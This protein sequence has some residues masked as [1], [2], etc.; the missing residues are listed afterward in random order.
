MNKDQQWLSYVAQLRKEHDKELN[1]LSE[2]VEFYKQKAED[3]SRSCDRTEEGLEEAVELLESVYNN[4]DQYHL[5]FY[6]KGGECYEKL[7]D[8]LGK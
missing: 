6:Y 3:L 7:K 2:K 4:V 8:Y 1:K 5:N